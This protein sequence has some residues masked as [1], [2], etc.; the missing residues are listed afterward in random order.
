M[1]YSKFRTEKVVCRVGECLQILLKK[2]TMKVYKIF[3]DLLLQLLLLA[4]NINP[5][6]SML[7]ESDSKLK[8]KKF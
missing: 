4:Y 8:T 3:S 1:I 6:K 5:E 2:S 7:Q